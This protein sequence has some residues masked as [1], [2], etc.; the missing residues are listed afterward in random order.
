[1]GAF[2]ITFLA[3]FFFFIVGLLVVAVFF[4]GREVWESRME[5]YA[6]MSSVLTALRDNVTKQLQ[7]RG[8]DAGEAA[9]LAEQVIEAVLEDRRRT[10][11]IMKIGRSGL[12]LI[13]R[14]DEIPNNPSRNQTH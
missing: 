1:M 14:V 11:S 5:D 8:K 13:S 7:A 10:Y 3:I 12:D 9:E 4:L 2:L 6:E